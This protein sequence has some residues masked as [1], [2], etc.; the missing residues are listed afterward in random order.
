MVTR[1]VLDE[2]KGNQVKVYI[3]GLPDPHC[4]EKGMLD[5]FTEHTLILIDE[6]HTNVSYIPLDNIAYIK[7]L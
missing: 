2:L 4:V 5:S 1:K 3:S 7:K 6:V